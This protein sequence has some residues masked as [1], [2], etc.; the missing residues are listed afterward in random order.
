[1]YGPY[2][3]CKTVSAPYL[4][5]SGKH[6]TAM[7]MRIWVFEFGV[8]MWKVTLSKSETTWSIEEGVELGRH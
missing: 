1:M 6:F 3:R 4:T 8:E 7:E 2:S 5:S